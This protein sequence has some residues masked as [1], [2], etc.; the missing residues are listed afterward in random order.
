MRSLILLFIVFVSVS[1]TRAQSYSADNNNDGCV[2]ID[3]MLILLSQFGSCN[4]VF[5][6]GE[7]VLHQGYEYST[8]QIGNQC[9][10]SENC[11]Y[12]PSVSPSNVGSYINPQYYVYGYNGVDTTIAKQTASYI[13]YGVLYNYSAITTTLIC[14]V[15]WHVPT[16]DEW[17]TLEITLGMNPVEASS[18]GYRGTDQGTKLKSS[19]GW[20]YS[21]NGSDISGFSGLPGGYRTFDGYFHDDGYFGYWWTSTSFSVNAWPRQ[22]FFNLP[23]VGRESHNQLDGLSVR[24]MLD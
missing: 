13:N 20:L 19:S 10:F 3:D 15:G 23:E 8:V 16:D 21:G 18:T 9:W 12:L 24:C 1:S 22:L 7:V 2:N 14:P 4:V 5:P 17:Q 11:R 6:C